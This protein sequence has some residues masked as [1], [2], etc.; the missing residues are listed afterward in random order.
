MKQSPARLAIAAIAAVFLLS[1]NMTSNAAENGGVR[2]VSP[3]G[4]QSLIGQ[5]PEI[6]VLDIRT[7]EEFRQ[8]HVKGAVNIDYYGKDFGKAI[9]GLD[10]NATYLVHCKS[11]NRSTNALPLF[12]NAG[13]KNVI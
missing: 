11:G 10:P 5:K 6:I 7:P 12:K 8:G 13:L 1:F 4:A 2:H 3:A 9:A